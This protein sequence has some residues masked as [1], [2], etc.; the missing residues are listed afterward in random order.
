MKE[1][2]C[3]LKESEVI[4]VITVMKE[5]KCELKESEVHKYCFQDLTFQNLI[6]Y[7]ALVKITFMQRVT[8]KNIKQK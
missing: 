1:K 3:E 5:K 4:K 2:K 7:N 8:I 6:K